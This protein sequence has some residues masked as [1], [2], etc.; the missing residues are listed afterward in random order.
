M[1]KLAICL[2][3][4]SAYVLMAPAA[5]AAWGSFISTGTT[6]GIGNPSCAPVS[7][8]NVACAVQSGKY[9]MMVNEF[10]GTK[11]GTWKSLA[12]GV[13]SGPSC[14]SD[15]KGNVFCA[16]TAT[17]GNLQV[18]IYNGTSWGTPVKV[19]AALYSAPGC[20]E[21]SSGQVLC[22]ARNAS[23]GL[24]WSLYNGTSWSAFAN[25]STTAISAPSCTTDNNGGVICAFFT[26]GYATL[27]ARFTGGAWESLIINIGGIA[28]SEPDCTFYKATGEVVCFAEAYNSGIYGSV[29]NGAS[30]AQGNWTGYGSLGGEV[31]SNAGCTSHT[32]GQLVC[33]SIGVGADNNVFYADVWNGSSWAGWTPIGG[34]GVGSP[35][36][37][38][39]GTGQAVCVVM[40]MDNK[41][42]SVVGP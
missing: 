35:A 20:A 10:N 42:T 31:N 22:V 4:L 9:T 28:G 30:W 40:G 11:W 8:G 19:K 14:T 1:K 34:S 37:A 38:P 27:V 39:L 13:S 33:G 21:Y 26:T 15:G 18:A 17:N 7:N 3:V 32:A 29:F 6:T 12:G 36:C 25:L 24:A 2:I 16:A 5:W 23:G 41:L